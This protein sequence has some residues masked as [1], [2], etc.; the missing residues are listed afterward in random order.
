MARLEIVRPWTEGRSILLDVL[1]GVTEVFPDSPAAFVKSLSVA[2]SG[3]A[4]VQGKVDNAKAAY[5]LVAA[6]SKVKGFQG[7]KLDSGAADPTGGYSFAISF[8]VDDWR[9]RK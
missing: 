3:K 2:E 4:S 9:A 1:G 8:E 5:D 6:L 7:V